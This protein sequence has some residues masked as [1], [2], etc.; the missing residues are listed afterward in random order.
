VLFSSVSAFSLDTAILDLYNQAQYSNA[1]N[2]I[3][4]AKEKGDLFKKLFTQQQQNSTVAFQEG[5]DMTL[6]SIQEE[7]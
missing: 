7:R 2:T 1:L 4:E 6:E 3:P 5:V